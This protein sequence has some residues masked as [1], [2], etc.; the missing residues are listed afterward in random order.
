MAETI[1]FAY[2]SSEDYKPSYVNGVH[3]GL[4]AAGDVIAH[5]FTEQRSIDQ[6]EVFN[7]L[8]NGEIG[9]PIIT[10]SANEPIQVTR[11]IQTGLVMNLET[12]KQV[13]EW[14]DGQI[15]ALEEINKGLK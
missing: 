2:R 12:A 4:N 6:E 15:T 14:L 10:T 11:F 9:D 13:S 8:P 1:R 3:G 5:F 7:L